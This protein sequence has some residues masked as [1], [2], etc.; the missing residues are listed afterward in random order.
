MNNNNFSFGVLFYTAR[1]FV[2]ALLFLCSFDV[3]A[4]NA[5]SYHQEIDREN[6]KTYSFALSPIPARGLYDNM[7]LEITCKDNV[8]QV[9]MSA[10]SLIASQDSN[11]DFE[12]QIDKKPPFTLQMK[13]FKDSKRK[14]YAQTQSLQ[15]VDDLLAG[16][17]V[18]IRVNTL[19]RTVLSAS[20]P[21]D[22]AKEPIKHVVSD[23]GLNVTDRSVDESDYSL[24]EFE[25]EF[26]KLST[27]QQQQVLG[28]I[29]HIIFETQK[30]TLREN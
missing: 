26:N 1:R 15:I 4:E 6:N 28:Q 16:K 22:N 30:A 14:G 17:V 23:C 25:Q 12:Y 7:R 20:F 27:E 8:L 24:A 3:F 5:W 19:I 11:F 18:F 2:F 10:D 13:T 21:L 29:K 9:I